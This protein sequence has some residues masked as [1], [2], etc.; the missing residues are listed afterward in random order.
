MTEATT[1]VVAHTGHVLVD[2][3]LFLG[4]PVA[5]ALALWISARRNKRRMSDGG[6]G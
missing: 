6:Q 1:L 5:M 3:P 4:P 2:A